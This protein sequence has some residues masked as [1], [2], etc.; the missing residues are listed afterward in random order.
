MT[1]RINNPDFNPWAPSYTSNPGNLKTTGRPLWPSA[2]GGLAQ[3]P[4][5]A[6]PAEPLP[7]N[8]GSDPSSAGARV[9]RRRGM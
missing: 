2:E 9:R 3:D 7:V 1:S 4:P 5:S 6:S 8:H